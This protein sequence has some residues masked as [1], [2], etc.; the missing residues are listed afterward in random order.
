MGEICLADEFIL[1]THGLTKEFAGF[2]AVR[3][4]SLR[5][6]RG[7]IHALIGPNGAG[8]TTC[9]NLLTKFL[10]PSAGQILY[11]GTDLASMG[12]RAL[13]QYRREVQIIFQD[14]YASLNPRMTAGDIVAEGWAVHPDVAPRKGR[15]R[16]TQELLERVGLN[17]DFVNRYPHQF[18]GGQRQRVGIAMGANARWRS[19]PRWRS[20]PK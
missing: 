19:Q 11:K 14:P 5:V 20:I 6:R 16:R 1:E 13:K 3:D 12:G 8:K 9:F 7:S 10:S 18:S 2:F 4:V 15:L 17:P